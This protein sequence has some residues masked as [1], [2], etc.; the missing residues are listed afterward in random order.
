MRQVYNSRQCIFLVTIWL[1]SCT[2][3][4][5]P[6]SVNSC[7]TNAP[8]ISKL[9]FDPQRSYFSTSEKRIMGLVLNE[10]ANPGNLAEGNTRQYQ[11]STWKQA[12]WLA[13][14]QIDLAGNVFTAPAPFISVL[15]NPPMQQNVLYKI[16]ANTGKMGAFANLP[17]PAI[18]VASV[19]QPFGIIGLAYLC[20]TNSLYVSS[21]FGSTIQQQ[22]GVVYH[23][24]AATGE[25]KDKLTKKDILGLGIAYTTG[26]RLLFGG[27]GRSQTVYAVVLNDRG[28]F[29]G[30][31]QP[32]FSLEGLGPRGDDKVRRI[33]CDKNGDLLV[34]GM[35]FNYNLIAPSEKQETVYRFVYN[36]E[37]KQWEYKP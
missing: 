2:S 33:K 8:F 11:D 31:W 21:I 16:D 14:L 10:A 25:I 12:G 37:V 7:K 27:D 24:D 9:G 20:E 34:Y 26:Q 15:N 30:Y 3:E 23:V 32:V 17:Q 22:A 13:P 36:Q 18:N 19:K 1:A 6:Y 5:I 4:S 29:S 35:E 28:N